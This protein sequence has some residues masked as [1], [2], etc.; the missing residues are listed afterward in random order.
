MSIVGYICGIMTSFM[1]ST[2][3]SAKD[4][5]CVVFSFYVISATIHAAILLA[6]YFLSLLL[7]D[8]YIS[9]FLSLFTVN[10]SDACV[11][12]TSTPATRRLCKSYMPIWT[13][14]SSL[15][16][17]KSPLVSPSSGRSVSQYVS[18][19][20]YIVTFEA[21]RPSTSYC[22]DYFVCGNSILC[23]SQFWRDVN[24]IFGYD[25]R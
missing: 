17:L 23:G 9:S 15:W 16:I 10:I 19:I 11:A 7:T 21:F 13:T 3:S 2:C 25:S 5:C 18:P 6:L 22:T 20:K 4:N 24:S 8:S 14:N 12:L 1:V